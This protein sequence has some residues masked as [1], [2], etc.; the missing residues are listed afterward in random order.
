MKTL[1]RIT[2]IVLIV[3]GILIMLG[4]LSLGILGIVRAGARVLSSLPT[5]PGLRTAGTFGGLSGLILVIYIF[6]QG[7]MNVAI[8]EGLYLLANLADKMAR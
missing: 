1:A 4:G 5:Q 8:G 2:A 7:L 6:V 3:L